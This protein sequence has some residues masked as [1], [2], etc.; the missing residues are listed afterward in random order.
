M[1]AG[2][3]K[4]S[5]WYLKRIAARVAEL[6]RPELRWHRRLWT[7]GTALALRELLDGAQAVDNSILSQGT[8]DH[9][10]ANLHRLTDRDEGLGTERERLQ[11]KARLKDKNLR[12]RN[13]AYYSIEQS[14]HNAR[15]HYLKRWG[16]ALRGAE[17][18]PAVERTSRS[19][20]THLLDAG[21]SQTYLRRRWADLVAST[22]CDVPAMLDDLQREMGSPSHLY[23][24]I[25]PFERAPGQRA[26]T[27]P[28]W[29]DATK[30]RHWLHE[31]GHRHA[32]IRYCGSV[33][34]QFPARDVWAASEH[35]RDL[36][37]WIMSRASVGAT[38]PLK[39]LG[40][41]WFSRV[42]DPITLER[43][44]R[45][46]Y[47]PS[48]YRADHIYKAKSS[49]ALDN[50][51][52]LIG[53][54]D[55]APAS[56]AVVAGW[57]AVESML[58]GP[59]EGDDRV[60]AADRMAALVT[61]AFVRAE[62]TLLAAVHERYGDDELAA[63]LAKTSDSRE[64]ASAIGHHI[65]LG[66]ALSLRSIEDRCAEA[67]VR[68]V[69]KQP[70]ELLEEIRWYT[71]Q[72]FR[73]LYRQRNLIVHGGLVSGIAIEATARSTA[74]ILGAGFDRI[75]HANLDRE[76]SSLALVA[77]A[78]DRMGRLE[79]SPPEYLVDLLE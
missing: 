18:A 40:S 12:A 73:R 65:A 78:Q 62:L 77:Q 41:I 55:T 56:Y 16:A 67:R 3:P 68:Q 8:F 52:E 64:R 5:K 54:F 36:V 6:F 61:C 10:R 19:I 58:I 13:V 20:A 66:E 48:L 2:E 69:L 74:P 71:S 1:I 4:S 72:S 49:H 75:V 42:P 30:T 35:V 63:R 37:Q 7:V 60:V 51:I 31:N 79:D 24:S 53:T 32:G 11:L 21:F 44:R 46:V 76:N 59:G 27:A 14:L 23:D 29:Q 70:S 17:V 15:D 28:L 26:S 39:P 38:G 34:F 50:A 57:S 22:D 25:V 43:D 33:R 9:L 47:V 45:G